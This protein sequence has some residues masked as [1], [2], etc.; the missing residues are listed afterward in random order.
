MNAYGAKCPMDE[1]HGRLLDHT[2]WPD[3]W[4]CP[5]N[6][7]GG[8]GRFFT[9]AEAQGAFV[10][11]DEDEM[12][13]YESAARA[14]ISGSRDMDEAVKSIAKSTKTSTDKVRE[15]LN[16]MVKVAEEQNEERAEAREAVEK[17]KAEK[18]K[19]ERK[20]KEPKAPRTPVE[21][22]DP[23]LFAEVRDRLGLRNGECAI[24]MGLSA[25]RMTEFTKT[26]GGTQAQYDA[27][28]GALEAFAA[29][30]PAPEPE[31]EA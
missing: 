19:R 7:H 4:W 29:S 9:T 13:V 5:A 30:K 14:I 10:M 1:S 31:P 12:M 18:P 15:R 21:R 24:A 3:R 6:A 23:A 8:N 27:W 16:L 22:L 2:D 25:S 11:E 26:K 28:V 17:A 20:A